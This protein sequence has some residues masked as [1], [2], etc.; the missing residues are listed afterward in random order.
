MVPGP[1][2]SAGVE[3]EDDPASRARPSRQTV[4]P[5]CW[6]HSELPSR[7]PHV[8]SSWGPAGGKGPSPLPAAPTELGPGR[9]QPCRIPSC[10]KPAGISG[11]G[12]RGE[13]CG[14]GSLALPPV[15]PRLLPPEP[16][17]AQV[18][19]TGP[20]PDRD[21][22]PEPVRVPGGVSPGNARR[23]LRVALVCLAGRTAGAQGR[24]GPAALA[25]PH[26]G[27]S[28]V[29]SRRGRRRGDTR[30]TTGPSLLFS[31]EFL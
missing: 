4:C 6:P 25:E 1:L 7:G 29:G 14:R 20:R 24:Q 26:F 11:P 30:G 5:V 18:P 12:P 27:P 19:R 31:S 17:R 13:G 3:G 28:T 9:L 21:G 10:P 2:L 15:P 23:G 16:R 22:T 8:G